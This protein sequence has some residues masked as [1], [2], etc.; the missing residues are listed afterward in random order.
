MW[1][2]DPSEHPEP[3]IAIMSDKQVK[4]MIQLASKRGLIHLYVV[5]EVDSELGNPKCFEAMGNRKQM[6]DGR[7]GHHGSVNGRKTASM[8]DRKKEKDEIEKPA[9]LN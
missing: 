5:G 1:Y 6:K 9:N 2:E 8:E 7:I 4:G 3:L